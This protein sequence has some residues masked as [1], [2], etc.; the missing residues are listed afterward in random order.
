MRAGQERR[1]KCGLEEKVRMKED[2]SGAEY[3]CG[4]GRKT[5]RGGGGEGV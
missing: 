3:V 4:R 1:K 2:G 5:T